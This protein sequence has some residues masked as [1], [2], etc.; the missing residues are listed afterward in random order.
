M[1][2]SDYSA[3]RIFDANHTYELGASDGTYLRIDYM[4]SGLGSNS[5]GPAL[6]PK[7]RLDDKDIL[8][9]FDIAL[10]I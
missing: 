6:D 8:F 5:C 10:N 1:K 4:D 2:V 9:E 3:R 7:W